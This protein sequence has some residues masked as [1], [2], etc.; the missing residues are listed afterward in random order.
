MLNARAVQ[1]IVA[2]RE[3]CI[4]HIQAET[5]S[6]R[7]KRRRGSFCGKSK[8]S[9]EKIHNHLYLKKAFILLSFDR[10]INA[11]YLGKL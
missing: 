4:L 9:M 7:L 11:F 6:F 1:P 2:E 3:Q 8:R 5:V 10:K